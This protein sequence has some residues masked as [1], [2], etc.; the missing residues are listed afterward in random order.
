MDQVDCACAESTRT[1]KENAPCSSTAQCAPGFLCEQTC[2]AVC[3]C[4][5][6]NSACTAA[7]DCPTSGTSCKPVSG[8]TIYGVCL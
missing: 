3:L 4:N 7:N 1:G 8:Q 2:R 6:Q 5:A